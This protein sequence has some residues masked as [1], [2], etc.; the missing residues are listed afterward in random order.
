[1][2][3]ASW[4]GLFRAGAF[5][6]IRFAVR[7]RFGRVTQMAPKDLLVWMQDGN[8][9]GPVL[10]D[11]RHREE[12]ETSHLTE[13]KHVDPRSAW[14]SYVKSPTKTLPSFA[15]VR[16]DIVPPNLPMT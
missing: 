2:H 9:Q 7:F 15:T 14:R 11:V 1:M 3:R 10:L 13:A 5:W 12:Y 4:I 8:R 6:I 16:L